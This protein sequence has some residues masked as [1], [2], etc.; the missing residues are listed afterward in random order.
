MHKKLLF[1]IHMILGL[2]A[3][4]VLLIIGLTGAILSFEKEILNTIN[5]DSYI[6]EVSNTS[7]L[8]TKEILEK[9]QEKKPNLG[10]NA[11]TFSEDKNS[12]FI[13]NV[14]GEGKTARRGVDYFINPYNAEILP[15]VEGK[16]FFKF[17]EN[18][19]RRL[20]IGDVGKQIVAASVLCL[21]VLMF[22]GIYVYWPR[23]QR[24]FFKSF[25]FSFK[26]KKRAFLSTMHSAIGMWV[27]PFYLVSSIT[28]LYWSYDWVKTSL[29]M[30]SGVEKPKREIRPQ[31][32]DSK[33]DLAK[34][35]NK[36]LISYD[37]L[38]KAVDLFNQKIENYEN[39]YIKLTSLKDNVYTFI[40]LDKNAVHDRAKNEISLN[41]NSNETI[42]QE[43]FEDK[44]LNERLMKSILALHTGEYF[45]LIGKILMFLASSSMAIFTITGLMMYLQRK[46]K[47]QKN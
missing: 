25:T 35:G 46:K 20:A 41:I 47:K 32:N 34:V 16:E 13:I 21:L 2:S 36:T 12:S 14:A 3:G 26:H 38:Q 40:Y 17:I 43:K 6:V 18:I 11:I 45:G 19:H 39:A 7:R 4:F 33:K 37:D 24:T 27:I 28:G 5:K 22:S 23:I 29:Y 30:V 44:A 1:K 42:K 10:I 8:S 9:F 31:N 15:T